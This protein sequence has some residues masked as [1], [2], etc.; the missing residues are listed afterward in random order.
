MSKET[1]KKELK[2]SKREDLKKELKETELSAK[3]K[4]LQVIYEELEYICK[5]SNE[6]EEAPDGSPLDPKKGEDLDKRYDALTKYVG[7]NFTAEY[8]EKSKVRPGPLAEKFYG[9]DIGV[10][11]Q[12]YQVYNRLKDMYV[13]NV[14]L[15]PVTT[16]PLVREY[17]IKRQED[18]KDF[19]EFTFKNRRRSER[20][21][22]EKVELAPYTQRLQ[23][24]I[25]ERTGR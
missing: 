14:P 22:R 5:A 25:K 10:L 11:C 1:L 12:E 23:N 18:Q 7:E 21:Y 20:S 3:D 16:N 24:M 13:R 9:E 2:D 4:E 19:D 8:L 6:W 15:E 17:D